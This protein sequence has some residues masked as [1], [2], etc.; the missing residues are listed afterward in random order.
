MR[1]ARLTICRTFRCSLP[2][3]PHSTQRMIVVC[4]IT[5][6]ATPLLLAAQKGDLQLV[7]W[8]LKKE[9]DVNHRDKEGRNCLFYA[10]LSN[11]D[12]ADVISLLLDSK[13]NMNERDKHGFTPLLRACQQAVPMTL[14][15]L[16]KEGADAND[17][18]PQTGDTGFHLLAQSKKKTSL[19]CA[20]L[21][22]NFGGTPNAANDQGRTPAEEAAKG[23]KELADFLLTARPERGAEVKSSAGKESGKSSGSQRQRPGMKAKGNL[24]LGFPNEV[25][26]DLDSMLSLIHICRCRRYAVCRSRWSPYH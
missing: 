1:S 11:A 18:N 21:L 25:Q 5:V 4:G 14:E 12:N 15:V 19:A 6:G 24:A 17:S 20:K 16:L 13:V 23:D 22:V 7:E 8:I 2:R 3:E 9:V 10:I 26:P